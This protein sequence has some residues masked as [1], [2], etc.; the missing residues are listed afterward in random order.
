MEQNINYDYYAILIFTII[1]TIVFLLY[2]SMVMYYISENYYR[3]KLCIFWI[4]YCTLIFGGIL[5]TIIYLL[6]LFIYGKDERIIKLKDFSTEFFAPALIISLSFMCFTLISTL[7]FDAITG[8]RL[9]IKMHKMKSINELDIFFL[10]EKF[11]NID[12][13]DI[14]KMKSH[15]IYNIVFIIINLGLITLEIFSY[16]NLHFK[17]SIKIYF[18]YIMRIYHF[19]VLIFLLV[20][21]IIMNINKKYLLKKVYNNPNR[22]GQRIYDAHFSQVVYFTDV[23]SFKLVADLIMNVPPS[24]FFANRKFDTFTLIWSEISIFIYIFLGGS[25]YLVLDKESKAGRPNKL[26]KK[27]FCLKNLDFHFGEKD[28]RRIIDDCDFDYSPEEREILENLN[29]NV[30]RKAEIT[31]SI[32]DLLDTSLIELESTHKRPK[33]NT[34]KKPKKFIEF[35][36]ISEFYLVHKL[37]MIYFQKNSSKYETAIRAMEESGSAFKNI[38]K[39]KK[40]TLTSM[41]NLLNI[42]IESVNQISTTEGKKLINLFNL[43]CQEIFNSFEGK[44]LLEEFKRNFKLEEDENIFQIESLF[45]PIFFNLFPFF[46]MSI[47]AI[48][49]SLNPANNIKLFESF[50]KK[51]E[52]SGENYSVSTQ[53]NIL[54]IKL[55]SNE[56]SINIESML[57]D[58]KAELNKDNFNLSKMENNYN[59]INNKNLENN[60]YYT[61]NMYLTYEIYDVSE[62]VDVQ[63][64]KKIA[65]EYYDYIISTVKTI[66]YTF[67]PLILGIFRIRIFDSEKII[68]LYRHPL[69]F[70]IYSHF[71]RWINFYLTEEREKIKI[72]SIFN[73]IFNLKI[74]EINKNIELYQTDFEEVK[75][76]IEQDFSFLEKIGKVFPILHLFIGE[77]FSLSPE[78]LDKRLKKEGRF[79]LNE[80]SNLSVENSR[81][82]NE[83]QSLLIDKE[84]EFPLF[85]FS[86]NS[87]SMPVLNLSEDDEEKST[88]TTFDEKNSLI[89]KEYLF[90]DG[91]NLRTIKIYFTNLFRKDCELNKK[92]KNMKLKLDS[93]SYC[94]YL[95]DQL[96]NYLVKKSLFITNNEIEED[97]DEDLIS[98][99]QNNVD[100]KK[101]E[102]E[103]EIKEDN[104][105]NI[106]LENIEKN[107]IKNDV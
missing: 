107:N 24:I 96:M 8:I 33:K 46:Q 64:L 100:E 102:K 103:E 106:K 63:E 85:D 42:T 95:K 80:S 104:I 77:E 94:I 50:I 40:N 20:S 51:H 98:N 58:T 44:E 47:K 66:S 99:K 28:V 18:N 93:N 59:N 37:M 73:D 70:S 86:N 76:S 31:L 87:N 61:F 88:I 57:N 79:N 10:S 68:V 74:I 19:L 75:S 53:N 16:T 11:N 25:E 82:G 52:N 65:H 22:I 3:K 35:K 45:S 6:R 101:E 54:N 7:L 9:S 23:L 27:L 62:I 39:D 90:V 49:D 78:M 56:S 12:Y 89:D 14:L 67:L 92:E 83:A 17:L 5:F 60:S 36:L 43:T 15:H 21:I 84:K 32:E 72:S 1:C 41:S 34:I 71:N 55:N 30:V 4:D 48:M 69:Y 91:N 26:I 97:K 38:D 29:I 81:L 2:L 105:E 13:A